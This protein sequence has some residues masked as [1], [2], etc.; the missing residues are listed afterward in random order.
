MTEPT[1]ELFSDWPIGSDAGDAL[2][3]MPDWLQSRM[4]RLYSQE[5]KGKDA[6][7]Y[8]KWFGGPATWLLTEYDR[9][10]HIGFGWCDLGM[11]FPELGYV[12]LDE[13]QAIRIPLLGARIERDLWFTPR[14]L[15]DAI[16]DELP[17]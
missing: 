14:S 8:V 2:D 5:G 7:V 4:P 13:V 15:R 17:L 10:E 16:T 3:L 9:T 1:T 11:A 12:H 6:L